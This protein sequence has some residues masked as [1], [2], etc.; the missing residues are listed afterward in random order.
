MHLGRTSAVVRLRRPWAPIACDVDP[1]RP[2]PLRPRP[3]LGLAEAGPGSSL[4]ST[5]PITPEGNAARRVVSR[6]SLRSS[7]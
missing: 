2:T 4:A 1:P 5:V 6:E 3:L 7:C